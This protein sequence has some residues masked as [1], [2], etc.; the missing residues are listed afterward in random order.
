M[1]GQV[2]L[3]TGC[4]SGMGL[5]FAVTMA[6]DPGQRYI[7]YATMRSLAKKDKLV[8]QAGNTLEKTLFIKQLDVTKE[9]EIK[10]IVADIQ[11]ERNCIDILV[12][13]A[14]FGQYDAAEKVPLDRIRSIF[15]TNT[16]GPIR[17]TQEVIP[18]MK[19]K[20]SGRIIFMGSTMGLCG[21]PFG[22]YYCSTK[23]AL[24]G[25][26][27]AFAPLGRQFNIWVS[28]IEPGPV[29]TGFAENIAA[30]KMGTLFSELD[31]SNDEKTKE[32]AR[33]LSRKM[34]QFFTTCTQETS[35]ITKVL[36]EVITAEKPHLRYST[37][38]TFE[39]SIKRKYVD[40][41]G[42]QVVDDTTALFQ[43]QK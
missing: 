33:C 31:D 25:F 16:I 40:T 4:S 8:K 29:K 26:A 14:A 18:K 28:T 10:Q 9:E 24:E 7:V 22:E 15:E 12:N 43:K 30:N 27:E 35:E 1:A 36:L 3:I 38:P 42:D 13:N 32:L 39:L 41:Y 34:T 2:V 19:E 20:N 23:F 21:C 6:K 37:N 5:D 11:S 17:L